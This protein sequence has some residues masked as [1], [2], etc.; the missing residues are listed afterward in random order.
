MQADTRINSDQNTKAR[1]NM[2]AETENYWL[3]L[4]CQTAVTVCVA[5][6]WNKPGFFPF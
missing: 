1:D 2:K 3:R 5:N 4:T 6:K